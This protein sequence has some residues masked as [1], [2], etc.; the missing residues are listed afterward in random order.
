MLVYQRV[1]R[2]ETCELQYDQHGTMGYKE[3]IVCPSLHRLCHPGCV[4][5]FFGT[6]IIFSGDGST[7]ILNFN[8]ATDVD[9]IDNQMDDR[10]LQIS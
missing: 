4:S 8:M 10:W 6:P 2:L 7:V 5:I 1:N 9:Q 3:Y